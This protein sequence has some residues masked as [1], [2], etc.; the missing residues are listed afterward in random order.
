MVEYNLAKNIRLF[1]WNV[2]P[3]RLLEILTKVF[4]KPKLSDLDIHVYEPLTDVNATEFQ[5]IK[6]DKSRRNIFIIFSAEG[7]SEQEYDLLLYRL[8]RHYNF[9]KDDIIIYTAAFALA[10]D[11]Y[12]HVM[13]L[14]GILNNTLDIAGNRILKVAPT[15]P[16]C[17]LNRLH[18]WQ[19][20]ALLERLHEMDLLGSIHASYLQKPA[21]TSYPDLYPLVLDSANVSFRDGYNLDVGADADF[22]IISESSYENLG[23]LTSIAVPGIT[24]KTYKT[25]LNCQMPIFLSSAHTVYYYRLMGFDAFDDIID[26]SYDLIEDPVLRIEAV[27]R[28]IERL[29]KHYYY[30][31]N[32]SG[33]EALT[34]RFFNN[35]Q[36][37][38]WYSRP[39][40]EYLTWYNQFEKIGV[41]KQKTSIENNST[42]LL[43]FSS[44]VVDAMES[45]N[46]WQFLL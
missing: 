21:T 32:I 34:A 31:E 25:I 7:H 27:A 23:D 26:H 17:F 35:Y 14:S 41:L 12:H 33:R 18:R 9:V 1:G 19:R 6:F 29:S 22:V 45:V 16:F 11:E 36:K 46:G 42:F 20:Q 37:L 10:T 40:S 8:H 28:E 4:A 2:D 24:E 43:A 3:L 39:E 44:F 5:K 15:K 30:A 38:Q 13:N